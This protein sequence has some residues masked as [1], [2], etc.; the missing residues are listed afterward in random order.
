MVRAAWGSANADGHSL[1]ACRRELGRP[2]R[3]LSLLDT[4]EQRAHGNAA[5][6]ASAVRE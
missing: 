5:V 6:R 4:D 1:A 3:A 2:P